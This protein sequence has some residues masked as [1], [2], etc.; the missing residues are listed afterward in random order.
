MSRIGRPDS[1]W[2]VSFGQ[3]SHFVEPNI[4]SDWHVL[5][6]TVITQRLTNS[7]FTLK[8]KQ[9]TASSDYSKTAVLQEIITDSKSASRGVLCIF[10]SHTSVPRTNTEAEVISLDAGLRM[11]RLVSQISFRVSAMPRE[12]ARNN[13]AIFGI[14]PNVSNTRRV[15]VAFFGKVCVSSFIQRSAK[16]EVKK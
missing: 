16:Q 8:I 11:D 10:G 5:S 12:N 13:H 1:L 6:A 7:S 2:T 9:W 4:V 15:K 14:R 3:I